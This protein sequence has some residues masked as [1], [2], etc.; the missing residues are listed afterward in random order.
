MTQKAGHG[1]FI[2]SEWLLIARAAIA[3][4]ILAGFGATVRTDAR[5]VWLNLPEPW[6]LSEFTDR[7]SELA[8]AVRGAEEFVAD[9]SPA[10]PAVRI[11]L[12]GP[13][14]R[15]GLRE[16]LTAVVAELGADGVVERVS[17][18]RA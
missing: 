11:G 9:R 10:P 18:W 2:A 4:D 1:R 17:K 5:H 3:G 15:D 7:M 8:I 13:V 16:A 14:S 6:R 12:G